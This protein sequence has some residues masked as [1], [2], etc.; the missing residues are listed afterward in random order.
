MK[1]ALVSTF[2]GVALCGCAA[3][4][5]PAHHAAHHGASGAREMKMA[6]D[7]TD[8]AT[9]P[10]IKKLE[11]IEVTRAQLIEQGYTPVIMIAFRGQAS[12][13]TQQSVAVVKEADR[14][15]ALKVKA[16]LR[17]LARAPGVGSI[18]QCNLPLAERKL[19]PKALMQEVKLVPNGWIALG[20]A[21][22]QGYA[23]IAP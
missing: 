22:K 12:F 16:L 20:E 11:N 23:Y 4:H 21:Q 10:L 17:D 9:T 2:V 18:V 6:F 19:D 15:D 7:V 1:Q 8:A 13:Y 5:D 14:A 3:M